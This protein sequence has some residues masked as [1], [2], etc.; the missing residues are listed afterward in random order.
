MPDLVYLDLS[1]RVLQ[2]AA[3]CCKQCNSNGLGV[4]RR[5]HEDGERS[6]RTADVCVVAATLQWWAPRC[7]Q[8]PRAQVVVPDYHLLGPG[9]S[10]MMGSDNP[11]ISVSRT[12]KNSS[13]WKMAQ[14]GSKSSLV[15]LMCD[16]RNCRCF[17]CQAVKAPRSLSRIAWREQS[18]KH[19]I[20]PMYIYD[21]LDHHVSFNML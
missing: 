8:Q 7:S 14:D 15:G 21:C 12:I 19:D 16:E 2:H 11:V 18:R 10:P 13:L 9:R 4:R 3:T 17:K 20:L 1:P 6:R 5:R